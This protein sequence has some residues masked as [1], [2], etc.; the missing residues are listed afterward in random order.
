M[1]SLAVAFR[2]ARAEWQA[3]AYPNMEGD[4]L[5]PHCYMRLNG[6]REWCKVATPDRFANGTPQTGRDLAAY[7]HAIARSVEGEAESVENTTA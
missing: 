4:Y 7:L 3:I 5:P 2:T 6:W 1:T